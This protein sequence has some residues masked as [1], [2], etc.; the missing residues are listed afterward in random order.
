MFIRSGFVTEAEQVKLEAMLTDI[1]REKPYYSDAEK[2]M[3]RGLWKCERDFT[4]A[5]S[6]E[7]VGIHGRIRVK[8]NA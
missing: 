4:I 8:K 2:M 3:M 5:E 6:K 7:I 1:S